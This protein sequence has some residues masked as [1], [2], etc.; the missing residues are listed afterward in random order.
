PP[1]LRRPVLPAGCRRPA[2]LGLL[3]AQRDAGADAH[4]P[5]RRR[6]SKPYP[7]PSRDPDLDRSLLASRRLGPGPP[8]ARR[9][10][11]AADKEGFSAACH[12]NLAFRAP[13]SLAWTAVPA[14]PPPLRSAELPVR[15]APLLPAA[16]ELRTWRCTPARPLPGRPGAR[17]AHPP[18]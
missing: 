13:G 2:F 1:G 12:A 10:G 5:R 7:L 6:R 3:N 17:S 8:R 14:P 18:R 9:C 11:P 16:D 4:L 15:P